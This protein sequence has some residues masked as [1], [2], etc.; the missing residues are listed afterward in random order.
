M[1]LFSGLPGCSIGWRGDQKIQANQELPELSAHTWLLCFWGDTVIPCLCNL[2]S[3]RQKSHNVSYFLSP[4]RQKLWGMNLNGLQPGSPWTFWAWR[5][6]GSFTF[7]VYRERKFVNVHLI[8]EQC[9]MRHCTI[10]MMGGLCVKLITLVLPWSEPQ[11]VCQC[12]QLISTSR[13]N[14]EV[15]QCIVY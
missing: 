9:L 14:F 13:Y 3:A 8:K 1:F 2:L 6:K 11:C 12:M 15:L 10:Y 4:F 5:G 7:P